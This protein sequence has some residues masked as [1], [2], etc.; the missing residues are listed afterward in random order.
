MEIYGIGNDI[1]EVERIS[2]SIEKHGNHFLD[3]LFTNKEI[4]YCNNYNNSKVH[5]AGRYAAKEAVSKALGVGFG[6]NLKW[7]EF[8][9]MN[10]QNGKPQVKFLN[11]SKWK[12][13][14]ILISISH[15]NEYATAMA[16]CL[17]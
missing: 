10:D 6:K 12:N 16:V 7:L 3:K 13:L 17:K 9:I 11:D 15:C 1:I 2:K 8:E 5:F 4:E 14:K